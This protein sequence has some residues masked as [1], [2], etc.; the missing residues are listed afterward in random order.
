MLFFFKVRVEPK[1]LS[2]NDLWDI[3]EHEGFFA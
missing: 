1:D 2:L 3:W